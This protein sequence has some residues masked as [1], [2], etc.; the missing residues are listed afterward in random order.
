MDSE[1]SNSTTQLERDEL[2]EQ[3]DE[4]RLSQQKSVHK[5]QSDK[6]SGEKKRSRWGCLIGTLAAFGGI[7]LFWK[8]ACRPQVISCYSPI[9]DRGSNEE[10]IRPTCYEIA[11]PFDDDI[12][13]T[14]SSPTELN[15]NPEPQSSIEEADAALEEVQQYYEKVKQESPVNKVDNADNAENN[16]GSD[17]PKEE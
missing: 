14:E 11:I 7:F 17:T 4:L 10:D 6:T 5:E 15:P 1:N 3:L 16:D 8:A 9:P 12:P 13:D 2:N